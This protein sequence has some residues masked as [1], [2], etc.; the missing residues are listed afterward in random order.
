MPA[1]ETNDPSTW[2]NSPDPVQAERQAL[3]KLLG[4]SVDDTTISLSELRARTGA[5]GRADSAVNADVAREVKGG[6][7][8]KV[9]SRINTGLSPAARK[10]FLPVNVKEYGA[11]GDGVV[12]DTAAILNAIT[13]AAGRYLVF[14]SGTGYKTT[15]TI[16]IPANI[17]VIMHSPIIYAGPADSTALRINPTGATISDRVRYELRVRR[18]SIATWLST[19]DRGILLRNVQRSAIYLAEVIGFTVGVECQGDAAGFVYN[20]VDL[21]FFRD[22]KYALDLNSKTA[23]WCNENHWRGGNFTNLNTTNTTVS[24]Y[25]VR[26]R[27]ED[28]YLQ[29]DNVFTKPSFEIGNGITGGAEA[30]PVLI[31]NGHYNR[32]EN[33]RNE[34]NSNTV[35]R[36]TNGSHSN[37]ISVGYSSIASTANV[38][39]DIGTNPSTSLKR[40]VLQHIETPTKVVY[41]VTD[42]HKR[43]VPYDATQV[44]IPG[45]MIASSGGSSFF[46]QLSSI[47]IANNYIEIAGGRAVGIRVDTRTVKSFVAGVDAEVGFGGKFLIRCYDSAGILLDPAL[48]AATPLVKGPANRSIPSSTLYGGVYLTSTDSEQPLFFTVDAQVASIFVAIANGT[49]AARFSAFRVLTDAPE[50][51]AAWSD[52]PENTT[53]P[54]AIQAPTI[55]THTVGKRIAHGAP[56]VGSPKGW[57]CTVAGT[58]GTWVSEGN[59]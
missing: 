41:S 37:F 36:V 50:V 13:A 26:I 49:A 47:T 18:S 29:D 46:R 32:F 43:A 10:A 19:L 6:F 48:F 57:I 55:G 22:N 53:I 34:S 56:A 39:E 40:A 51:P 7:D 31:E 23:G 28:G 15:S 27:S 38:I 9:D 45:L 33:A 2:Q 52:Y 54:M 8:T 11:V 12:D 44:N 4:L 59:L 3:L 5:G 58:P 16:D 25:A 42:I 14:P 35:M 20:N 24:R 21:G 1:Y 30:V 17:S